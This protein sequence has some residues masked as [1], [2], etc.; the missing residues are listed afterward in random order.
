MREGVETMKYGINQARKY[1]N[2]RGLSGADF[3]RD[4][5]SQLDDLRR[6]DDDAWAKSQVLECG[7]HNRHGADPC[8]KCSHFLM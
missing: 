2:S 4:V 8:K 6:E 5:A 1:A 3:D 7:R